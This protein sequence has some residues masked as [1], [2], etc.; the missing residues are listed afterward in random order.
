MKHE[1]G[2]KVCFFT[3]CI[4]G[5]QKSIKNHNISFKYVIT[6]YQKQHRK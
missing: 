6:G 5:N 4:K 3:L 1:W 2:A